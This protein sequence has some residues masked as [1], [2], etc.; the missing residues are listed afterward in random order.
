FN[1]PILESLLNIPNFKK[2]GNPFNTTVS[3]LPSPPSPLRPAPAPPL[4]GAPSSG[5][6]PEQ[7]PGKHADGPSATE[8]STS[9]GKSKTTKRVVWISIAGVFSFIIIVLAILLLLPK[10]RRRRGE[11]GENFKPHQIGAYRGN[12]ENL[13]DNGSLNQ[14]TNQM[15]K[16]QKEA[17]AKP[18][19]HQTEMRMGAVQSRNRIRTG[20]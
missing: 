3:P 1:G 20:S 11:A 14:P 6:S 4:P 12:R 7:K 2:D 10:C 8:G 18:K 13:G 15:E 17:A 19:N 16:V 5:T 9:G